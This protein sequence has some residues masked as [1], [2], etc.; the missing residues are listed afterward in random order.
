MLFLVMP[1]SFS[2][3]GYLTTYSF[4]NTINNIL[5]SDDFNNNLNDYTIIGDWSID[6]HHLKSVST[7]SAESYLNVP[8]SVNPN[9]PF[10]FEA[11]LLNDGAEHGLKA[12]GFYFRR[13]SG[14]YSSTDRV[15]VNQPFG[16]HWVIIYD[17]HKFYFFVNGIL[18]HSVKHNSDGTF[19]LVDDRNTNN[20]NPYLFDNIIISKLNY[21]LGSSYV[22]GSIPDGNCY[23]DIRS[24]SDDDDIDCCIK[25]GH[26]YALGN[27]GG[28]NACCGNQPNEHWTTRYGVVCCNNNL[29]M[30]ADMAECACD[31]KG[32]YWVGAGGQHNCCGDDSSESWTIDRGMCVNDEWIEGGNCDSNSDCPDCSGI[33]EMSCVNHVC[34]P[35][36]TCSTNCAEC[37]DDADCS[38]LTHSFGSYDA[39]TIGDG[40]CVDAV[41]GVVNDEN[42]VY[43][44]DSCKDFVKGCVGGY[45][46]NGVC[47]SKY[48]PEK[49]Y[50]HQCV[51]YTSTPCIINN[52][53]NFLYAYDFYKPT[54]VTDSITYFPSINFYNK[55]LNAEFT[56]EGF[57]YQPKHCIGFISLSYFCGTGTKNTLGCENNPASKTPRKY[58]KDFM[59]ETVSGLTFYTYQYYDG[60][61]WTCGGTT[62]PHYTI[63]TTKPEGLV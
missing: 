56:I 43:I 40:Y 49:C 27:Y 30:D 23:S 10:V 14:V 41:Q 20:N 50:E 18:I 37:C 57:Y 32:G 36:N 58:C 25:H 8:L 26:Q 17:G 3:E 62:D 16:P 54:C 9:E 39:Y 19:K 45:D 63:V 35:S 55:L 34:T 21:K 61:C 4:S 60:C 5:F 12:G 59:I 47:Y 29:Y 6:N 46:G 44:T 22:S 33:H 11:T 7:G 42:Y 48:K 13:L 2:Y 1:I 38:D 24:I 51:D 15:T 53:C 52:D 31:Q 28:N